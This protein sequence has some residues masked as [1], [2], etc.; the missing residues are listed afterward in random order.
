MQTNTTYTIYWLPPGQTMS[1][2]YQSIINGFFQNVASASGISSTVYESDTQYYMGLS[3]PIFVQNSSTFGGSFVD[4][5]SPI[6]TGSCNGQYSPTIA[7]HLTGC[8]TDSQIQNEIE[9]VLA[10]TGWIPSPTTLF[11]L[12]TPRSVGSCTDTSSGICAYT[13]YCAYHSDY[14][15]NQGD[16]LYANQPYTE[17][18]QLGLAGACD[19][20]QHPNGDWADATLNVA[21]HEHNEAV[22]DPDGNAWYDSAGNE[23]GDKCAWNFGTS[24]G[25]TGFG[26]YNQ[27]IGT[28]KYYLQQEW[29]NASSSCALGYGAAGT[30][31]NSS[32]P[33]ISGA[34][35][36]GQTLIAAPGSWSGSPVPTLIYQWLRCDSSGVNCTAI[37]GAT[38]QSYLLTAGDV[39]FTIE[40]RV[41]GTNSVGSAS[42]ASSQS[43]TVAASGAVGPTTPVLDGF[44]RSNGGAGA[45]WSL[46]R[47][48]GFGSMNVS[49]NAAVDS[50]TTAFA[51]NYWNAASFGPDCEAYVTIASY[52]A[53]DTVRIGARVI[54]AGTSSASG[55]FVQVSA[56]GVWS[57]V[58][59][60]GGPSATLASGPTQMLAA[61]DKIAIRIV[62][63]VV[64]ALHYASGSG[65]TQVLSYDTSN[66]AIR[67]TSAGRI[68]LE[69][70]TSTL[71]DLGGGTLT[72]SSAPV[73]LS[74]PTVSGSLVSGQT[75]TAAP[76]SWSGSPSPSFAYQWERCDSGGVN[77]VVIVGATLSSY[78]LA[79]ADVGST[80]VVG[81]TASNS[82]GSA[83]P[84]FSAPTGVVA[85]AA[86]PPVNLSVPTVSGSLVSGQTLTAAP[87]SWSGSPSPSFAYQ[88]ERCD[89]GGVN[90]VVIVGATLSS[91]T[92]AGADVGST[93]VVGVTASNSAGSAGPVFSAPTG[94]VTAGLAPTTPVLDGFNRSN[95]GAGAGWSLFRPTGFGSMNVSGNAAVDS[96]T[97]AF[98]W[99]YWNAASFGPDCEAYVT[100]ASYGASDTVRIGARVINAGTSSAS[101]YF[102][103]VSATGVWSIVRIDGGPSATLASGP[104]QMLAAGD[105]IAIRIV[106]SVVTA[107]HYA[108]G[109]GW[110]QVLSYDTSNDAIRYTSA[111]RIALEFK[112][113]TLDDLGGGTI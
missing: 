79:G 33:S 51:W 78:T 6:P 88:W 20:G 110:T 42:A 80:L 11:L 7:S 83:G 93:L 28:G 16:V 34:A 45:G 76:G 97:T 96:S 69:F 92:L 10:V 4:A 73:N 43:A 84:V 89:S 66:D 105:K 12:F 87:G 104:T 27:V 82:A 91:Y 37:A 2:N 35:V 30:P 85:A 95:G 31:G 9:H 39:G 106:G 58:R 108:S 36:Q 54:N 48:T 26:Q 17:T 74:V 109:S 1:T 59:I 40:V 56:T 67:Y 8:V 75:L 14:A 60:D 25:S 90:C 61:G 86:V 111:G 32:P 102:V 46:F 63:S 70:K 5:N 72:A 19:S 55:Y 71:D 15:D 77:C 103:Q 101:G 57:I 22:T 68:A 21:S 53:S 94:V 29:S 65:W 41:T 81:V 18:A 113:S 47:P 64:T 13:Y 98:A 24:L 44:N 112:T 23:N 49:G 99:N 3:P 50:S 107:L 62:G 100:I 38:G 52:G